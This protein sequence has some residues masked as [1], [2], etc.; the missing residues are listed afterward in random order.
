[1]SS[2][3]GNMVEI[4]GRNLSINDV[5]GLAHESTQITLA[6]DSRE[7]IEASRRMVVAAVSDGTA[8]YGVTTGFGALSDQR[9]SPEKAR[10]LQINLLRSHAAGTGPWLPDEVVRAML[11][12]R[13]HALAFGY[14]GVRLELI[15]QLLGMYNSGI[16]PEV[17]AQGSVGASGD[18]APLAHLALPLTGDGRVRFRGRSV[19]AA[20]ALLL[21]YG[22]RDGRQVVLT[23]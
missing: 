22:P 16:I 6:A 15:E 5:E 17:P 23:H 9:I 1:M 18:L 2:D 7:K 3:I 4:G 14:S 11:G 19:A 8:V 13:A 10:E 12:L 21:M 20:D